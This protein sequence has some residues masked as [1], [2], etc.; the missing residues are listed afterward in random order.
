MLNLV[1]YCATGILKAV[2]VV[3]SLAI[4]RVPSPPTYRHFFQV[5][6]YPT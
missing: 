6:E 1:L 2:T 5:I 3:F 4:I